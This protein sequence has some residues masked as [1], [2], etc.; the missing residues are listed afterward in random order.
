MSPDEAMFFTLLGISVIFLIGVVAVVALVLDH[1]IV[2]TV[3]GDF[4]WHGSEPCWRYHDTEDVEK[5]A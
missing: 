2:R 3:K 1:K 5:S 4:H